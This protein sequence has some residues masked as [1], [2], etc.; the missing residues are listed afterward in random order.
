MFLRNQR[1]IQEGLTRVRKET[2]QPQAPQ[3]QIRLLQ[4]VHIVLRQIQAE[5]LAL[6]LVRAVLHLRDQVEQ[7]HPPVTVH[8]AVR[9]G[10]DKYRF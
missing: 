7:D 6:T 8:Q 10:S 2:I 9:E 5:V 3:D 4:V 1:L